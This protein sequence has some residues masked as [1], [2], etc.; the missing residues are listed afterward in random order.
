VEFDPSIPEEMRTLLL[1]P[2]T[3]GGLLAAVEPNKLQD[4]VDWCRQ[5]NLLVWITGEV[6][7]G[8]GIEVF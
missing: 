5:E 8:M 3:S 4:V 1:S 7:D 6:V 2:E